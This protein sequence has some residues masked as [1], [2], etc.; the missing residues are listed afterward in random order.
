MKKIIIASALVF[1]AL[2]ACQKPSEL[3]NLVNSNP[4]SSRS[5]NDDN[6]GDNENEFDYNA[7]LVA[8]KGEKNN[9]TFTNLFREFPDASE[10]YEYNLNA[11]IRF[12]FLSVPLSS[13]VPEPVR[14]FS[15]RIVQEPITILD[16]I[17]RKY[18]VC[19]FNTNPQI[20]CVTEKEMQ[21]IVFQAF[22]NAGYNV[23]NVSVSVK[24]DI[25]VTI[26]R[27]NST[28]ASCIATVISYFN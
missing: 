22:V 28:L 14:A 18:S 25:V 12:N 19:A 1:G 7:T 17:R 24:G 16:A 9:D 2:F 8:L 5:S 13:N 26:K 11:K 4:Q 10:I 23:T 15:F 3:D 6:S 27:P 21:K 20:E